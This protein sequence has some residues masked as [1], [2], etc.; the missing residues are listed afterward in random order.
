MSEFNYKDEVAKI[1]C[2][3]E[4]ERNKILTQQKLISSIDFDTY[5]PTVR[6]WQK[7]MLINEVRCNSKLTSK[8][9]SNIF[10]EAKDISLRPNYIHFKLNDFNCMISTSALDEFYISGKYKKDYN[11]FEGLS[12]ETYTKFINTMYDL[13]AFHNRLPDFFNT[14]AKRKPN[15][16][17]GEELVIKA[18]KNILAIK[19]QEQ[20]EGL[21]K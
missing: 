17:P 19:N 3:L 13:S 8:L 11:C 2:S 16:I 4:N 1:V 7:L 9:I 20:E 15:I 12:E 6:Q 5:K 10:P 21:E 14:D 18:K